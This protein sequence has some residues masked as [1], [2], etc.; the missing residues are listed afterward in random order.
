MKDYRLAGSGAFLL[1]IALGVLAYALV[2]LS[3]KPAQAVLTSMDSSKRMIKANP[4]GA[5]IALGCAGGAGCSV[6]TLSATCTGGDCGSVRFELAPVDEGVY[7]LIGSQANPTGRFSTSAGTIGN[8]RD[9]DPCDAT[10]DGPIGARP[11]GCPPP[12][13]AVIAANGQVCVNIIGTGTQGVA[14]IKAT[15]GGNTLTNPEPFLLVS[16][17]EAYFQ[18]QGGL[19]ADGSAQAYIGF[20]CGP[21]G[22]GACAPFPGGGV[23]WTTSTGDFQN[24]AGGSLGSAHR[25][26]DN[27]FG[28]TGPGCDWSTNP[29]FSVFFTLDGVVAT[30]LRGAGISGPANIQANPTALA[31]AVARTI[32]IPIGAGGG[33]AGGGGAGGGGAGGGGGGGGTAGAFADTPRSRGVTFTTW[34]GGTTP[35]ETATAGLTFDALWVFDN[36]AQR[37]VGYFPSAPSFARGGGFSLRGGRPVIFVQNVP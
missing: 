4:T 31:G 21:V 8:C 11:F 20:N 1:F 16:T 32:T 19:P 27:G 9:G 34:Q 25:C 7:T 26:G 28:T 6:A 24:V 2:G 15:Q 3:P 23:D 33:G 37:Y 17:I 30:A 13:T 5:E 22:A 14:Q 36:D 12:H 29:D 10:I 18:G 35:V